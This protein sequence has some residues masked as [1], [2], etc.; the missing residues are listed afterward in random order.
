MFTAPDDSRV[1]PLPPF[2]RASGNTRRAAAV[3]TV[4]E[5]RFVALR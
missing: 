4:G 1:Y 2:A 3:A 5:G